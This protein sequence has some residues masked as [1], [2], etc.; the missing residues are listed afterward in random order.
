MI[1]RVLGDNMPLGRA[2]PDDA[3]AAIILRTHSAA[4]IYLDRDSARLLTPGTLSKLAA[5]A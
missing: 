1:A 2:A 4:N 3:A 5:P